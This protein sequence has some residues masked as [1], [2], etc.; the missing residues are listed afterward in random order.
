[1]TLSYHGRQQLLCTWHAPDLLTNKETMP[2]QTRRVLTLAP[3][4]GTP[5]TQLQGP[6]V[7]SLLSKSPYYYSPPIPHSSSQ[8]AVAIVN[9]RLSSTSTPST[10]ST[11]ATPLYT[12]LPTQQSTPTQTVQLES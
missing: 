12:L 11:P 9:K 8:D 7:P 4:R 6:Y 10:V 5:P 1:M 2:S 3:V